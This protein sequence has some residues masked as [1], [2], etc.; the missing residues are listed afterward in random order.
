MFYSLVDI[1]IL[2]YRYCCYI[3]S[4]TGL[5]R[6]QLDTGVTRWQLDTGVTRWQLDTGLTAITRWQT[7]LLHGGRHSYYTLAD[8][9]ITHW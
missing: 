3:L 2:H 7:Q 9:A 8:T 4:Y 5:T 6:W 1:R